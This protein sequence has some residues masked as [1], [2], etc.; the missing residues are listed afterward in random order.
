MLA[1]QTFAVDLPPKHKALG[2]PKHSPR[3][4]PKKALLVFYHAMDK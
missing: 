4:A 2:A 3:A 1:S